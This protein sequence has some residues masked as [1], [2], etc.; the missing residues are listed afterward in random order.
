MPNRFLYT[1]EQ[2]VMIL[3]Y[4]IINLSSMRRFRTLNHNTM[5]KCHIIIS[6]NHNTMSKC[7]IIISLNHNTMSKCHII[8]SL[9]HTSL[10]FISKITHMK[11]HTIN[12]QLTL[13]LVQ[14]SYFLPPLTSNY[15]NTTIKIKD[16]TIKPTKHIHQ[17]FTISQYLISTIPRNHRRHSR[18]TL[19]QKR[20]YQ[21]VSLKSI[22]QAALQTPNQS[23]Y[24]N[25]NPSFKGN[26]PKSQNIPNL[27]RHQ[28]FL[29]MPSEFTQGI[30]FQRIP[31]EVYGNYTPII[32]CQWSDCLRNKKMCFVHQLLVSLL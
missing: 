18:A 11:S 26:P 1:T 14:I 17:N 31:K 7:H 16:I 23:H 21:A 10:K 13:S 32:Q 29:R 12:Q 4:H 24:L 28:V 3:K 8:I 19:Y 30:P 15:I 6:L 5:S 27:D 9:N 20:S 25:H 22:L 2:K